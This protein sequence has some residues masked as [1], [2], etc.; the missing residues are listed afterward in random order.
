MKILLIN[1]YHYSRDGVT[2]AY[3]DLAEI[4]E[5][6]G[7]EVALFSSHSKNESTTNGRNI[8]PQ[9]PILKKTKQQ[10]FL[11]KIIGQRFL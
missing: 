11:N 5:A 2:R 7:H 1:N 3:F 10:F 9:P 8:L 6:H 4:L